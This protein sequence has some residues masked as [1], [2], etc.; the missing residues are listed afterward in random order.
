MNLHKLALLAAVIA[1]VPIL[2]GAG[3]AP[4][5]DT[6]RWTCKYC[7]FEDG[8]GGNLE[9]GAGYVSD[10]SAKFGEY[11]AL[12][13]QGGY[14]LAN[15]M[16]RLRRRDG[17]WLDL[18]A[19][20]LGLD[21]RYLGI[22]GGKQGAYTLLLQYKELQHAISTSAVT[23]FLGIGTGTLSLPSSWVPGSTTGAMSALTASLHGVDLQTQRK[24]LALGAALNSVAHWEFALKF[25]HET[26]TGTQGTAGSFAFNAAQL[27]QP[28]DYDTDQID[29][30]AAYSGRRLQ[31]R[32]AYYASKFTNNEPSLIW[33]NPF[34]TSFAGARVGQLAAAPS[35]DFHQF[36]ASATLQLDART[37]AGADLALGQMRQN[38]AF[39][40][41]TLNPGLTVPLPRSSLDGRVNTVSANLRASSALT[42]RLRVN[43]A[44][45]Y[46][47]RDNRTA[48][49]AFEWVTTDALPATPRTNLPYSSTHK[50]LK[51]DASYRLADWPLAHNARLSA[52]YEYDTYQRT[53]QEIRKTRE[54]RYWGKVS[55]QPFART[56]FTLKGMH[57]WRN[58]SPYEPN[59]GISPPENPVLRKYNM[60]DRARDSVEGRIDLALTSRLSLGLAGNFALDDYY[61]STLGLRDAEEL[62]WTA[63]SALILTE[64]TSASVYLNH[65]QIRSRQANGATL[66][67]APTWYARNLDRI[68]TAGATLRHHTSDKLDFGLGYTVSRSTGQ[69]TIADA[70]TPF[71]ELFFRLDSAQLYG[72]YRL[73]QHLRLHLAYWHEKFQS[74]DWTVDG[75]A[76]AT[77]PNVLSLAQGSPRYNLDVFMLSARYEF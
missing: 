71:P 20:D 18:T 59:P 36:L 56:E 3:D 43:A 48:P 38:E 75:V 1:P 70:A 35:N 57:A 61:K 28:I 46:D 16:A 10:A 22:Q 50:V 62:T 54:N 64:S 19:R 11:N 12:D 9:L 51:V 32:L 39:L 72:N 52:G 41:A 65:Q 26:K 63:D 66:A 73:R 7:P 42:N 14:V 30:S 17:T 8:L 40:P 60:A 49:A 67:P 23:P 2:A 76:P 53:L 27:V 69:V 45:S 68:D 33:S 34:L 29:A 74:T 24:Q 25:R 58:T 44:A 5:V 4:V 77:I 55:V 47:D 37:T 6:S 13:K 21:S 31:A 15:G